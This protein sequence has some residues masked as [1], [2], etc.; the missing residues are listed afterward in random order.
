[1]KIKNVFMK[2]VS[3]FCR[4]YYQLDAVLSYKYNIKTDLPTLNSAVDNLCKNEFDLQK[5]EKPHPI[6]KRIQY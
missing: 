3:R 5:L 4:V 2:K 6:F 1:M